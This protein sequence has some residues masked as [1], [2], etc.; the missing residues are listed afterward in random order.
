MPQQRPTTRELLNWLHSLAGPELHLL[1]TSRPEHD[2]QRAITRW[3]TLIAYI[4]LQN[5][6]VDRDISSY[7][8]WEV[9]NRPGLKRWEGH[10]KVQQE[11]EGTLTE[12]AGGM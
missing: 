4:P 1:V 5:Q 3:A 8:R 2:I 7:I 9:R 11:I 12:K 10:E 6:L